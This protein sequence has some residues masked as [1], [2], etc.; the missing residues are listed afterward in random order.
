MLCVVELLL[1][2][3]L[4]SGVPPEGFAVKV[5]VEGV[6]MLAEPGLTE[7]DSGDAGCVI[8]MT[9]DAVHEFASVTVTV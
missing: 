7:H 4:Y 5:C 3:K 9:V 2:R 1:Q 8:V 6:Q